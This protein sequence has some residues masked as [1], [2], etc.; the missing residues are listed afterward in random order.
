MKCQTCGF[1]NQNA[2]KFCI[3]CGAPMER[4]C[5]GCGHSNPATAKFCGECGDSLSH[6][7]T[8]AP[9]PS[10]ERRFITV[11]FADLVGFTAMSETSDAEDMRSML[12]DYFERARAVIER[13]GGVVDKFIG[14][15]ITAFWGTTVAHEDDAERA[16][17]AGLELVDVVE[18]LGEEI[19]QGL[20]LRV[21]ILS[22][23]TAVGEG[24]NQHGLVIG[25]IV[26]TAA[27]IQ[28][29]AEPGTVYVGEATQR[30]TEGAIAYRPIGGVEAKGKSSSVPVWQAESI[31][32][33]RR[34]VGRWQTIEPPFV[35]REDEFRFLKDQLH[36][37]TR[38]GSARLVSIVGEPGIGKSRIAWE[39]LKYVD[40]LTEMFKWHQ[41]RSPS[42][43]EGVTL[44]ALAEMV[45]S[46][47][48]ISEDDA[49]SSARTRL[50]TAVA[51]Y[52]PDPE[53]QSWIE[54][55]LAG[56]LGF[57]EIEDVGRSELFT[58][59]RT[60][61]QRI[62]A[63]ETVVMLFEDLHWADDGQLE[64]IEELV[65]LSAGFPILVVTLAR[66]DL[67]DRRA[68][69]G[70][71][72]SRFTS[73]H[74]GP[75]TDGA[76]ARLVRG[77]VEGADDELVDLVVGR[78]GGIPLYA[79]EFI[80]SLVE[81]GSLEVEGSKLRLVGTVTD[82]AIPD[83]LH[84]VVGSRLDRLDA[85]DR[86]LVQDCAIL[87]QSF[88]LEALVALSGKPAEDLQ[89]RLRELTRRELLRLENDPLSPEQGQYLFVQGVIREVAYGRISKSDQV[90]RH[91]KVAEYFE[92]TLPVEAAAIIADH[93]VRAYD[94]DRDESLA[95][96]ARTAL[97]KAADRAAELG[98]YSQALALVERGLEVPGAPSGR[99]ELLELGATAASATLA[100]ARALEMARTAMEWAA[101][102]G[103]YQQRL[104]TTML[105]GVAFIESDEPEDAV[106]LLRPVFDPDRVDE[107][108]MAKLGAVYANAAMR[109]ADNPEMW[110]IATEVPVP[111]IVAAEVSGDRRTLIDA[112]TTRGTALP[113]VGRH[114][115]GVALLRESARL[116][117]DTFSGLRALNNLL[118]YMSD[119]FMSISDEVERG[120]ALAGRIGHLG[121]RV[122][123][124]MWEAGLQEVL[125]SLRPALEALDMSLARDG[126][127]WESW[128]GAARANIEWRISG[129]RAHLERAISLVGPLVDWNE[130]QYR[131]TAHEGLTNGHWR[132]G[133]LDAAWQNAKRAAE[134]EYN[135]MAVTAEF[136][137]V[138]LAVGMRLRDRERIR[139]AL[140]MPMRK[141]RRRDSLEAL[142]ALAVHILQDDV[143]ET[144]IESVLAEVEAVDGPL[145]AAEWKAEL[146]L[147]LGARAPADQL[148]DEAQSYFESVGDLGSL[149]RHRDLFANADLTA[150][151]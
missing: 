134:Y 39:L 18:G 149:G 115:E 66:T 64:F 87:G 89:P 97:L 112:M 91:V 145:P 130:P 133:D 34:G 30:L 62:A 105:L 74:L 82:I 68:D 120:T 98:S 146:A 139:M 85:A 11:L 9:T 65:E 43:G 94:V 13:F 104:H 67:L 45:R 136:R 19:G 25:D 51:E 86:A 49:A 83:S 36:A 29:A 24:G 52:V 141:G 58:A 17:R 107:P 2:E 44:W 90:A 54:P 119:G 148:A 92:D 59:I 135:I 80:R 100:H 124:M 102:E 106:A 143:D 101:E 57:E 125:G 21:G 73:L 142:A 131:A 40:G 84:A 75:L 41:G 47:A 8:S 55:K 126:G 60:F 37:T 61:F 22:G 15:A 77:V 53:E 72:H 38:D 99:L 35:G 6:E 137:H 123:L 111:V 42:Y 128:V 20:S 50:R 96:R 140:E 132:L 31:V 56:L 103:S 5:E 109:V 129:D 71:S 118:L 95:E 121:L 151:G 23:E 138:A 7:A 12:T 93:Y 28:A 14:D 70:T 10:A 27:R 122:R 127:F 147:L 81:S 78:A 117:G 79:V 48:G 32:G 4:L 114:H 69:W 63:V 113:Q 110:S 76:M 33:Q 46:R 3:E 88:T 16:V 1:H 26:N 108:E 144:E 116:A 150:T